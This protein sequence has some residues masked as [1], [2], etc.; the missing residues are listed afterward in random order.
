VVE[1][2]CEYIERIIVQ[3]MLSKLYSYTN[4]ISIKVFFETGSHY[5]SQAGLELTVLLPQPPEC[6]DYRCAPPCLVAKKTQTKLF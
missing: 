6:W 3:L 5:V 1:P 2:L 4:Y